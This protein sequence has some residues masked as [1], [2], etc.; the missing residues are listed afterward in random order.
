[1][2]NILPCGEAL[3]LTICHRGKPAQE[4][5]MPYHFTD[6]QLVIAAIVLLVLIIVAVVGFEHRRKTRT[7]AF[8]NRFGSEYNRAVLEHGSS[9]KAEAK[10]ADREIRVGALKIRELGAT[11]R[12]RFVDEWQ[13]VQSRFVDHPK[14]AVTE[15]DD[16]ISALLEARG[17]PKDNFEQRAAD[18][19]VSYPRVME[20]YR[21]AHSI[22]VRPG[23]L[24]AS[25][26]E[27]RTA[28]IQ[29]RAIFD[30]LV[31]PQDLREKQSVA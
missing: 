13:M 2:C 21:V 30:E 11:E 10:L 1:V 6:T 19:S 31:Q 15:A 22:A 29:Y 23:R 8:R 16:L 3:Y 17:Y 25:T 7:Q 24:E 4:K 26:E 27:L 18:V 5:K 12:S 20:N 14:A 28:M 9:R